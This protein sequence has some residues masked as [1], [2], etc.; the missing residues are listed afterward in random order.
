MEEQKKEQDAVQPEAGAAA[1]KAAPAVKAILAQKVGMTRVYDAAG[2][3]TAVTVL[4]AGPCPIVE[5]RTKAV[6]G[7][8]SLQLAFAEAKP[9]NVTKSLTGH[10]KK[11]GVAPARWLKEIRVAKT[12]GFQAG[13]ELSVG[14]FAEGDVVDVSGYN[15]GKGF[16]GVV[17]RH[18]FRG[19]PKTHGQSDR[20]RAPGSSGGQRPQKV[21]KGIRGPGQMGHEWTTVQ[22]V[23]VVQVDAAEN[24][25]LL[26]GSV[27]GPNGSYLAIQATVRPR[28]MRRVVAPV[29]GAKKGG[30]PTAQPAKKPAK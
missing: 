2:R 21:Y 10:M 17:K 9:K 13:Q 6:H 26:K 18:R 25:L 19:G 5:V 27:P 1:A 3:F 15:K 29:T 11:A 4:K 30:K 24:L 16:A 23:K 22:R 7:Y 8:D 28:R 20:W 14:N 12:E